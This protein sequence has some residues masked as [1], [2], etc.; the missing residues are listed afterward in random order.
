MV[1]M[2]DL[3][4]E[5]TCANDTSNTD[6]R[7]RRKFTSNGGRL[8]YL[9]IPTWRFFSWRTSLVSLARR[10]LVDLSVALLK[11]SSSSTMWEQG[12]RQEMKIVGKGYM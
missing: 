6:E 2:C 9:I 3:E 11:L 12:D 7:T 4:L 8:T 1:G 10:S 5:L